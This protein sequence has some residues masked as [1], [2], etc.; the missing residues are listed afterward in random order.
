MSDF[1]DRTD[2]NC[3][4]SLMKLSK[5]NI[6]LLGLSRSEIKV[7]DSLRNK[8]NTPLLITRHTKI[9]RTTVYETLQRLHKRGLINT[10]IRSGKK[11]WTQ[12]TDRNIEQ[13]LYLTKTELLAIPEGTEEI[14]GVSDS[15]V[16]VHRGNIAVKTLLGNL[17]KEHK[18]ERLF[19]LQ[20]DSAAEGW[21]NMFDNESFDRWNLSIKDNKIITEMIFPVGLFERMY[22]SHGA[23]WAKN[24][25]GRMAI[26]N[27][28]HEDYFKHGGQIFI[29][30]S[31]LYLIAVNEEIVI[32]IRN[33]EM[34]KLIL[35][36]FKFIQ[37]NSKKFDVNARLRTLITQTE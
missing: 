17:T 23:E 1:L 15:T 37:D 8:Y 19:A 2:Y 14:K 10:Y 34:Q 21:R 16:L 5:T 4:H 18:Q 30:K 27:E 6:K 11:Y 13:E 26:S 36:M 35:S 9:S 12:T 32:E 29:F 33:S 28:I 25:E 3:Y 22:P 7:L 24:F 20:G 31:S